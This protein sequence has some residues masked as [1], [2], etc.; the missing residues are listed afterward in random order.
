MVMIGG[1][2]LAAGGQT[3]AQ[4]ATMLGP[5]VQRI[6][7][8]KTDLTGLHAF[9]LQFLPDPLAG[10][11]GP[12]AGGPVRIY[13]VADDVPLLMTAIQDQLGLKLQAA[14]GPVE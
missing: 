14:R 11:S 4:L 12:A 9:D 2:R 10:G 13:L 8:D 7:V 5:R 1:N 6:V 3:M